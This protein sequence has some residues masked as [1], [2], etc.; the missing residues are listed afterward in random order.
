MGG[1][2]GAACAGGLVH[3]VCAARTGG[4]ATGRWGAWAGRSSQERKGS[5]MGGLAGI[6]QLP[7]DDG[8]AHSGPGGLCSLQQAAVCA[9]AVE[10]TRG[11]PVTA[12]ATVAVVAEIAEGSVS[13]HPV[14]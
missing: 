7:C 11:L 5:E 10:V 14:E 12:T 8:G 9:A 13:R 6:A 3:A 1:V 2:G 4:A